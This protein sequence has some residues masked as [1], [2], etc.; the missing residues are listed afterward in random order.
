V[1]WTTATF[2]HSSTG[3]LLTQGHANVACSACHINNNY[4]FDDRIDIL[5]Q[6]AMPP[7]YLAADDYT[8][9]LHFR[10]RLRAVNCC[11]LPYSGRLGRGLL[12]SQRHRI[13]LTGTHTSPTPTPCAA[14]H[15]NNNYSLNF[16]RLL[17]LPPSSIRQH[18]DDWRL[19]AEPRHRRLPDDRIGVR[20]LPPDYDL[21]R[22]SL[23]SQRNRLPADEWARER[24]LQSLPP[25]QPTTV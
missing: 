14:C 6:F 23:Q 13:A 15:I 22:G 7:H 2:D 4:S 18:H 1:S 11:E 12:R 3:F 5:R 24:G 20:E 21:V 9:A 10:P 8:G 17:R 16:S 19:S 25:Q